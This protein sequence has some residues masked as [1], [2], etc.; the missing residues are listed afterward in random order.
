MSNTE[1]YQLLSN[2]FDI[3][4]PV[5]LTHLDY[6]KR[7]IHQ[8]TFKNIDLE[9][10]ELVKYFDSIVFKMFSNPDEYRIKRKKLVIVF[11]DISGFSDLC[12]NLIDNPIA[13]VEL[14]KNY[15]NEA[16]KIIHKHNGIL[17]KFVG[18]GIMAYFGINSENENN[19]TIHA[20]EAAFEIRESF[21]KIKLSWLKRF[22]DN[23]FNRYK[24]DVY[25]KCGIHIGDV[26]FGLLETE[27]RNQITVIGSNVNFASRLVGTA[28]KNQIII[29]K[30]ILNIISDEFIY[31]SIKTEIQ[32]YGKVEIY[33]IKERKK[34][35][36]RSFNME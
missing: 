35:I 23:Y 32:S 2:A 20:V 31:E 36:Q 14:L 30:D 13:I 8:S 26:L 5:F 6:E 34:S 3:E 21:D 27:Y 15:F 33:D 1:N 7:I 18:D 29:S 16:N 9:K 17:D 24:P 28:E 25:L 4:Q 11:W 22:K 12:N 10:G 19:S